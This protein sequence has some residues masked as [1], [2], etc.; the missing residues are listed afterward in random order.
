MELES[1]AK[2]ENHKNSKTQPRTLSSRIRRIARTTFY[3]TA[4]YTIVLAATTL[5]TLG[6]NDIQRIQTTDRLLPKTKQVQKAETAEHASVSTEEQGLATKGIIPIP[7]P[8]EIEKEIPQYIGVMYG[9]AGKFG[10]IFDENPL[11]LNTLFGYNILNKKR[12]DGILLFPN[13]RVLTKGN[14]PEYAWSNYVDIGLGAAYLKAPFIIGI[15][16]VYRDAFKKEGIEGE[17]LRAW[18]GYYGAWEAKPLKDSETFPKRFWVT[19]YAEAEFNTLEKNASATLRTDLNLDLINLNRIIIGPYVQGKINVDTGN[20]PW[21]RYAQG[22]VGIRIR[23]GLFQVIA[24][25]GYRESFNKGGL[26]GHFNAISA[27]VFIPF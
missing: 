5:A 14:K 24:E 4:F 2:K 9:E 19:D 8:P 26:E 6:C 10:G 11:M 20:K 21:N 3:T 12:E 7:K 18:G 15:E 23:R 25:T 1:I 16:G 13:L 22:T 27:A 17:F